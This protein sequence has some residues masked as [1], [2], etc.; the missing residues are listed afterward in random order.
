MKHKTGSLFII[1]APSGAGK[2]SLV[3]ELLTRI[4]HLT[5]STSHTTRAARQGEE[6]GKDY[7][8]VDEQK[9]KSMINDNEFLEYA[10]V[11]NHYY[12]TAKQSIEVD[13]K[14]GKNIILEIDW[15][16][17]RQIKSLLRSAVS[18]FVLPPDYH[19]LQERL[20]GRHGNDKDIVDS[21][22]QMATEEMSHFKEYDYIVINDDFDEAV[23]ELQSIIH[24]TNLGCCRQSEFYEQFVAEIMAQQP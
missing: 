11:F 16:G 19:S 2:T 24:A 7:F 14:E 3:K 10:Y 20:H 1:S 17:A 4:E 22:M 18:I 6:N 12:G 15:Q 13:L 8:F 23:D 5:V 21:R 9:F